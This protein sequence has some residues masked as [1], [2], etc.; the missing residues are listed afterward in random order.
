MATAAAEASSVSQLAKHNWGWF[1]VRGV[2]AL[3]LGMIAIYRPFSALFAFTLVFAPLLVFVA[4]WIY[5]FVFAFSALWFAHYALAALA[6]LRA[7]PPGIG[8]GARVMP[9]PTGRG[10]IRFSSS[11]R[12]N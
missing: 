1:M 8:P 11:R 5:T 2:L 12:A 4:V 3:I 6:A 10:E 7:R 9:G